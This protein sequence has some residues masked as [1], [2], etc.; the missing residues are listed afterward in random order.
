[1]RPLLLAPC[2]LFAVISLLACG[3]TPVM[4]SAAATGTGGRIQLTATH[5]FDW[6]S[7]VRLL[8]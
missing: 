4:T 8:S 6:L 7:P 3:Q 5:A 1:M 2:S